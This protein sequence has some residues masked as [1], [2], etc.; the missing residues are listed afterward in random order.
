MPCGVT[1]LAVS[2]DLSRFGDQLDVQENVGVVEVQQGDQPGVKD[3]EI[4]GG[5]AQAFCVGTPQVAYVLARGG[6]ALRVA[7]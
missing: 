1:Y 7:E 2:D 6:V 4:F 3:P 5:K